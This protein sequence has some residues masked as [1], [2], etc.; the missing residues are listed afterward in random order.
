MK[1]L[2]LTA[3]LLVLPLVLANSQELKQGW[4]DNAVFKRGAK[5]YKYRRCQV[6]FE[7]GSDPIGKPLAN[8]PKGLRK[9]DTLLNI[10]PINAARYCDPTK[11]ILVANYS[12]P[13]NKIPLYV[14]TYNGIEI[15]PSYRLQVLTEDDEREYLDPHLSPEE[16]E[17]RYGE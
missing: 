5:E 10:R 4:N 1:S 16:Y 13:D 9:G 6:Y 8:C 2:L 3:S 17:E 12:P 11:P 15:E 14:C 7:R